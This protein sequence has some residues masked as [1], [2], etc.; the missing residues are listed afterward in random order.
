MHGHD[1][2]NVQAVTSSPS[3]ALNTPCFQPYQST[4]FFTLK[5]WRTL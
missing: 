3:E 4:V 2:E 1:V 5:W